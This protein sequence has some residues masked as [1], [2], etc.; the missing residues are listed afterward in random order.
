MFLHCDVLT[1]S[2][3]LTAIFDKM[4]IFLNWIFT[5][6]AFSFCSI[7][8]QITISFCDL[9]AKL[10]CSFYNPFN[11]I[12]FLMRLINEINFLCCHLSK[13]ERAIHKIWDI[14]Q[15]SS[16]CFCHL[17][18]KLGIFSIIFFQF[19]ERNA[20]NFLNRIALKNKLHGLKNDNGGKSVF[21]KL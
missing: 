19:S 1:K 11:K 6:F 12:Y 14:F 17:L 5:K 16:T 4:C 18:I 15:Y 3:L 20:L 2:E 7:P 10:M 9:L 13:F 21:W 8:T